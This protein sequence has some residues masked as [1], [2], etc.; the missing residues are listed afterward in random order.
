MVN[1]RLN[2]CFIFFGFKTYFISIVSYIWLDV[3]NLKDE[4]VAEEFVNRLSGHLEG[5]GA[6]GNPEELWSVFRTNILDVAG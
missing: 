1:F 2:V 5:L 6:L 3:G 4:R